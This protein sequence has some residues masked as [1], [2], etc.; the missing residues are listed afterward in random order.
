[1]CVCARVACAYVFV[2][3]LQNQ[4]L[5]EGRL[6]GA[7]APGGEAALSI[8]PTHGRCLYLIFYFIFIFISI[9]NALCLSVCL[10][11]CLSV[12]LTEGLDG[13]ST[14]RGMHV[15]PIPWLI[16]QSVT[17]VS[18]IRHVVKCAGPVSKSEQESERASHL[19]PH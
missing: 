19:P 13:C 4:D 3:W 5:R 16:D 11:V 8:A 1:M 7:L 12:G 9:L 18:L 15:Y 2:S 17:I 14:S 10:P 6:P